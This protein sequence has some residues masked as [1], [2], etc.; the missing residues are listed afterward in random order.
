MCSW[1]WR[2]SWRRRRSCANCGQV[3]YISTDCHCSEIS[4]V[5]TEVDTK[6]KVARCWRCPRLPW[7]ELSPHFAALS[8][9]CRGELTLEVDEKLVCVACRYVIMRV[10][11][12]SE[13]H[14]QVT[15]V[16]RATIHWCSNLWHTLGCMDLDRNSVCACLVKA[17]HVRANC[18][19]GGSGR[20]CPRDNLACYDVVVVAQDTEL[21]QS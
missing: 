21:L 18:R 11:L 5:T 13:G 6:C 16:I 8:A 19:D 3:A 1:C 20:R 10:L 17:V 15:A 7:R 4:C 14:E 9:L 12:P 2:W